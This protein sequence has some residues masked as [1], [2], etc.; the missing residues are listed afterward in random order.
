MVDNSEADDKIIA[1]LENDFVWGHARDVGDLPN[2]LVERLQHYFLTYKLVPGEKANA[3]IKRIYG[4][5]HALK[6]VNAAIEDYKLSFGKYL[7][8]K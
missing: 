8:W 4:Y 5:K 1:V 3:Y 6:V 7:D 2:V